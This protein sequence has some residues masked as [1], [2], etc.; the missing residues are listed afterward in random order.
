MSSN[1]WPKLCSNPELRM[2]SNGTFMD[3]HIVIVKF[4]LLFFV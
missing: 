3:E 4:A 2:L 1:E